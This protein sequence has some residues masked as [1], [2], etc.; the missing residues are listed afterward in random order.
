ML[1]RSLAP[2]HGSAADRSQPDPLMSSRVDRPLFER[3]GVS[4]AKGP[5][6][7]GEGHDTAPNRNRTRAPRGATEAAG[8]REGADAPQRRARAPAPGAALDRSREGLRVRYP[9]RRE[10]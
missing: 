7:I 2:R 10:D 1:P 6:R 8:G 5:N 3:V 9:G 4:A